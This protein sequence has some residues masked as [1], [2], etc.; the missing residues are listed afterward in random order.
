[1]IYRISFEGEGKK[2]KLASPVK[3]REALLALRNSKTNLELL[4][5]ARN[6][7][8]EAKGKL[9]QLAYNIGHV[10]GPIAGCKS[11]GSFFFHDVDCYENRGEE[12]EVRGERNDSG[13]P[14]SLKYSL[15]SY[16]LLLTSYF[17]PLP[18]SPAL[19]S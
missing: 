9:L 17:S 16:F 19:S 1:M 2:K 18:S 13:L 11:I 3:D 7:D 15:T 4:E 12:Q 6:G 8:G 14:L 10:D 5:K